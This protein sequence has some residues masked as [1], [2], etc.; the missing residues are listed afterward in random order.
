[1]ICLLHITNDHHASMFLAQYQFLKRMIKISARLFSKYFAKN[2]KTKSIACKLLNFI[3]LK[4]K[5]VTKDLN[6]CSDPIE[7]S[8][9]VATFQFLYAYHDLIIL[10]LKMNYGGDVSDV[11]IQTG[12]RRTSNIQ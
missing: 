1:M 2:S 8:S 6:A 4:I 12:A 11:Q 9:A 10:R 5:K 3:K 7:T